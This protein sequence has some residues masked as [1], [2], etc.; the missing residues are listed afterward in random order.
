MEMNLFRIK[1]LMAKEWD[2]QKK[3]YLL[4]L[5][6]Y[7]GVMA[8]VFTWSS[9]LY[10]RDTMSER[11]LPLDAVRYGDG[12]WGTATVV[13]P[14]Y[15]M[16]LFLAVASRGSDFM[17]GVTDRQGMQAYLSLPAS[18]G[19]KFL[20]RWFF[21]V[22]FTFLM[23]FVAFFAADLV[24]ILVCSSVYPDLPV[25]HL[26]IG[27][28]LDAK[29]LL[30]ACAVQSLFLLGS[31]FWKKNGFIKTTALL[32][33]CAVLWVA[34]Y[35]TVA[36]QYENTETEVIHP[37]WMQNT[38]YVWLPLL[39]LI[40]AY[41][42]TYWRFRDMRL[43]YA[44]VRCSAKVVAGL[45]ILT[46]L[47]GFLYAFY[48]QKCC[49]YPSENSYYVNHVAWYPLPDFKHLVLEDS[50]E[51]Y[52]AQWVQEVDPKG[53]PVRAHRKSLR[54]VRLDL[55]LTVS[56]VDAGMSAEERKQGIQ[57]SS[58]LYSYLK[59]D[60]HH[61]TLFLFF[62]Y[63]AHEKMRYKGKDYLKAIRLYANEILICTDSLLSV[64]NRMH[65]VAELS[66]WKTDSLA[67][68]GTSFFLTDCRIGALSIK[69][70]PSWVTARYVVDKN[71]DLGESDN[72]M[73][74]SLILRN[75]TV[76]RLHEY[77]AWPAYWYLEDEGSGVGRALLHGK[78]AGTPVVASKQSDQ[79]SPLKDAFWKTSF[80]FPVKPFW[81]R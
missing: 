59:T 37:A 56:P 69:T 49:R 19:E 26:L 14:F 35:L 53:N 74:N 44:R 17:S 72:R 47:S 24:R 36:R 22:P 4:I 3:H 54:G 32:V 41:V 6:V 81:K 18:V 31:T 57:I 9:L 21:T 34:F 61:D 70:D 65:T 5:L 29:L 62:D 50:L 63:P 15:L 80:G 42:L 30:Q 28:A 8:V 52:C 78:S 40:V 75:S 51:V 33:A 46:L 27:K 55:N 58:E 43:A 71:N 76:E 45:L 12:L 66:H 10:G 60:L 67:L 2:E 7:F 77:Q 79:K 25:F 68:E 11:Y 13:Y 73:L 38:A 16:F 1:S 48:A 39:V 64:R 20:V 23:F